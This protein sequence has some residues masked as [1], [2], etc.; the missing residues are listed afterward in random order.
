MFLRV[1]PLGRT[2]TTARA[3]AFKQNRSR[4]LVVLLLLRAVVRAD[5]PERLVKGWIHKW[6]GVGKYVKAR[7]GWVC[8]W[9]SEP[10]S[11]PATGTYSGNL[12]WA[13]VRGSIQAATRNA[14]VQLGR[15]TP[16]QR[17]HEPISS[18]FVRPPARSGL[19]VYSRNVD[20]RRS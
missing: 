4:P 6:P 20:S 17:V 7:P 10:I 9:I 11:L 18:T 19:R 12:D 13:A 8:D 15:S 14:A 16:Y 3:Q 2:Y 5:Y 1:A